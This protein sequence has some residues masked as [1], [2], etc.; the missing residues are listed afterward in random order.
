MIQTVLLKRFFQLYITAALILYGLLMASVFP[1]WQAYPHSAVLV[2]S[3]DASAQLQ[4]QYGADGAT[5]PFQQ[6]ANS[7]GYFTALRAEIPAHN[8]SA[9]ALV[10]P[11]GTAGG[12]TLHNLTLSRTWPSPA[13]SIWEFTELPADQGGMLEVLP[14]KDGVR[15]L[16]SVGAILKVPIKVPGFS[17]V[18]WFREW[19]LATL[20]Y[21][22]LAVILLV[23]IASLLRFP[24][25]LTASRNLPRATDLAFVAGAWIL[26]SAIHLH[27]VHHSV[28]V[29][30]ALQIFPDA[31]PGYGWI[32]ASLCKWLSWDLNAWTLLQGVIFCVSMLLLSLAIS[33]FLRGYVLGIVLLLALISPAA[34]WASR[35]IGPESLQ[36]SCWYVSL[37]AFLWMCQSKGW[38]RILLTIFT[39]VLMAYAALLTSGGLILLVL[40]LALLTGAFTWSLSIQGIKGIQ[41]RVFWRSLAQFALVA[42]CVLPAASWIRL[43]SPA[44]NS[45]ESH[46][47]K[48]A[49]CGRLAVWAVFLPDVQRTDGSPLLRSYA[50]LPDFEVGEESAEAKAVL[51]NLSLWAGQRIELRQRHSDVAIFLYN[52]LMAVMYP[53][54]Y[55]CLFLIA[56]LA[57]FMAYRERKLLCGVLILPFLLNVLTSVIR[58]DLVATAVQ[59]LDG[60]LWLAAFVGIA[61]LFKHSLQQPPS[62]DDRRLN[63]P[64]RPKR[65][66]TPY[67]TPNKKLEH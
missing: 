19:L 47:L 59:P 12:I 43:T 10:F 50:V 24:D 64:L 27:L 17:A 8:R 29:L 25:Q 55:R 33:P 35:H 20:S 61:A 41:T 40:P 21:I 3:G 26:G 11:E 51:R 1:W 63:D 65:F 57:W 22:F 66:F 53:W 36:A 34:V 32:F 31:G 37:A 14:D 6:V 44:T 54:V 42:L 5:A 62:L 38:R 49:Q 15:V 46:Q 45:G 67:R 48:L 7:G 18:D 4:F 2:V 58:G 28:P 60:L 9:F 39:G 16:A 23:G 56:V 13:S 52:E 30:T